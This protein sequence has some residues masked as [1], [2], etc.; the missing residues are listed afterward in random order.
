MNQNPE[1]NPGQ[2]PIQP[3]G[4]TDHRPDVG[5][6]SATDKADFRRILERLESIAKTTPATD[7]AGETTEFLDAMKNADDEFMS[8][9]DLRKQLE[10]AYRKKQP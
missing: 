8:V 2:S 7:T 10:D 9:M 6:H 3:T 1:I 4:P 5:K